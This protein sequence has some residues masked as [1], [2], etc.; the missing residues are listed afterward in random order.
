M[1]ASQSKDFD[2]FKCFQPSYY[3]KVYFQM[4]LINTDG[5]VPHQPLNGWMDFIYYNQCSRAFV[6]RSMPVTNNCLLSNI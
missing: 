5:Y 2:G 3:E 6:H 4:L 1:K